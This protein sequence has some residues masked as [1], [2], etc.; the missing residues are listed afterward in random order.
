V[1][2]G[3]GV[4]SYRTVDDDFVQYPTLSGER[5]VLSITEYNGD[6]IV[7]GGLDDRIVS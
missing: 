2:S 6:L 5:S 3:K 1:G 7:G 4:V